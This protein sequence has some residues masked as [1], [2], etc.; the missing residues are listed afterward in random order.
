MG[1]SRSSTVRSPS[2]SDFMSFTPWDTTQGHRIDKEL[3]PSRRV[4]YKYLGYQAIA[5]PMFSF[6]TS[7]HLTFFA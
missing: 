5:F 7:D 4:I 2:E 6:V 1:R 3:P